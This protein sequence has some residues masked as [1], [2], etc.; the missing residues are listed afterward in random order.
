MQEDQ[1]VSAT[2]NMS[3]VNLR[4]SLL[5]VSAIVHAVNSFREGTP[6]RWALISQL[7]CLAM[8]WEGTRACI[9]FSNASV[10]LHP[11]LLLYYE[12]C[13]QLVCAY[14]LCCIVHKTTVDNESH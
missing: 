1:R 5:Q 13:I 3:K 4:V 14:V 2:T 12:C 10:G 7:V 11:T 9:E 6:K 8:K